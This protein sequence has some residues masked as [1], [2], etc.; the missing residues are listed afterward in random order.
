M[1]SRHKSY[2]GRYALALA[3]LALLGSLLAPQLDLLEGHSRTAELTSPGHLDGED[4]RESPHLIQ[5]LKVGSSNS[6]GICYL[7]KLLSHS[8]LPRSSSA[9]GDLVWVR[10]TEVLPF[11]SSRLEFNS[12]V[13]RGP[14]AI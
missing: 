9:S 7:H 13:S 1:A 8:L 12:P 2:C 5:L 10:H 6:C 3:L 14:P 11:P 4:R